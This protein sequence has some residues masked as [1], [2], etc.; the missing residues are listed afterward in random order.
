MNKLLSMEFRNAFKSLIHKALPVILLIFS[1]LCGIINS[2]NEDSSFDGLFM[3]L[4]MMFEFITLAVGLVISKDFTQNTIRNK[5]IVGHTRTNIYISKQILTTAV[6]L[7][8]SVMFYI[9]YT[10]STAHFAGT[11]DLNRTGLIRGSIILFCCVLSLSLF[12]NFLTMT[13]KSSLGAALPL[14]CVYMAMMLGTFRD[15]F[16]VK[17]LELISEIFPFGNI[18]FVSCSMPYPHTVRCCI[19]TL[20]FGAACFA[21]G[22]A[23]FRKTNLN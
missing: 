16:Q 15:I 23:I 14:L 11:A 12:A 5:I 3:L 19:L 10:V 9:G 4:T 13:V 21:G 22:L 18:L 20:C 8:N 2:N 6:Y 1:A 7:L 17:A